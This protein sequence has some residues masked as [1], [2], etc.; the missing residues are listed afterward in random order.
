MCER[1]SFFENPLTSAL[2][3]YSLG[4]LIS[5]F[6]ITSKSESNICEPSWSAKPTELSKSLSSNLAEIVTFLPSV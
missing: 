5:R 6:L 3:K 2:L 1:I 4:I